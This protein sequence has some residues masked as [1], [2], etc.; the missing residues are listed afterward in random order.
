LHVQQHHVGLAA[1]GFGDHLSAAGGL[2][3]HLIVA[4]EL[5]DQTPQ[6]FTR[7]RLIVDQ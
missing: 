5:I 3:D 6:A 1:A 7:R 2:A 4:I